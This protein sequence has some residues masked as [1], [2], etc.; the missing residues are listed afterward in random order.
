MVGN[1]VVG[2]REGAVLGDRLG[3]L[4]G[5]TEGATVGATVRGARLG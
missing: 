3:V 2:L 1:P 5:I 4:D